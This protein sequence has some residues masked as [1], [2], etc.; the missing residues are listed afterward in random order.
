MFFIWLFIH[1]LIYLLICLSIY[2]FI[3]IFIYLYIYF[4]LF[5]YYSYKIE[6]VYRKR[7]ELQCTSITQRQKRWTIS[8]LWSEGGLTSFIFTWNVFITTQILPKEPQLCQHSCLAEHWPEVSPNACWEQN[9]NEVRRVCHAPLAC[10]CNPAP[11]LSASVLLCVCFRRQ[12]IT[13]VFIM[14]NEGL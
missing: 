11:V 14:V 2:L 13:R 7:T 5:I 12:H 6:Q 8:V 9:K 3:Y 4:Y 10:S 1:W